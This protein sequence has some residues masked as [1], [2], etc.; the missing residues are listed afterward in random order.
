M[1]K[2][3]SKYYPLFEEVGTQFTIRAGNILYMQDDQSSNLY[4]VKSGRVRMF[5]IGENGKE[6]TYRI[7]GEGQLIGEAAFLSHLQQATISAV[8]D[9]TL[10]TCPIQSLYPHIYRHSELNRIIF[11]LLTENYIQLCNQIKRLTINDSAKRVASYLIDLTENDQEELG[12]INHILPYTQEE[13]SVCLNLHRTTVSKV[14]A[15]FAKRGL[16][17]LGYRKIQ[18][19]DMDG[20]RDVLQ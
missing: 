15:D 5:Y 19:T 18:V 9:T 12:I 20:L 16:V 3:S 7:I 10:I 14:L 11:E 8:T 6:I 17:R 4:L 13:L 2:L 1:T